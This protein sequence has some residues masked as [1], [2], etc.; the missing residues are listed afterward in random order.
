MPVTAEQQKSLAKLARAANRRLERATK[1]QRAYLEKQIAKYHT[2]ERAEGFYVFQQGK[3]GSEAEYRARMRELDTFMAART[4][5]RKGWDLIKKE[6]VEAAG[7]TIRRGGSNITDKELA[8]VLD[9]IGKG[10][11]SADF[12]KALANVEISKRTDDS[13]TPS[14][15]NIRES[16]NERRTAQERTALLLQLRKAGVNYASAGLQ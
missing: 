4:S 1:G 14:R 15:E 2:R 11:S 12:Y 3:A 13:W 8:L 16:I 6:Q 7:D 9:E 10:H 5:T